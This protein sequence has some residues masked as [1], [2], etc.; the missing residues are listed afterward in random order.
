MVERLHQ[1]NV[2]QLKVEKVAFIRQ[3][4]GIVTIIAIK[5]PWRVSLVYA[6][7]VWIPCSLVQIVQKLQT[8]CGTVSYIIHG[9]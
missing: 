1:A 3:Q 9:F 8:H 4:V 5:D 6:W 2:R 7:H